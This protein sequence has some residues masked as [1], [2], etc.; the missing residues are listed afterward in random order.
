MSNSPFM[1]LLLGP[2]ELS[3]IYEDLKRSYFPRHART[4]SRT[5]LMKAYTS[6]VPLTPHTG[7][8]Q[9]SP[10]AGIRPIPA[11]DFITTPVPEPI[12]EPV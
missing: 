3:A 6:E 10:G 2:A 5:G 8:P 4:P 1:V 12:C 7:I 11:V 9:V